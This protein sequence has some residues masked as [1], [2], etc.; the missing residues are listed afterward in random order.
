MI[1]AF[2]G[3][4]MLQDLYTDLI[5]DANEMDSY[6]LQQGFD[7]SSLRTDKD[8]WKLSQ[9]AKGSDDIKTILDNTPPDEVMAALA[10]SEDGE[11]LVAGINSYAQTWGRRSDTVI[12]I[13]DP[14]W[15]E[16]PTIVIANLKTYLQSD[17]GDPREH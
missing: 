15:V 8:L 7:N 4:S 11:Q 1:P 12:E 16:D 2:V 10:A 13:G 6:K 3:P 9:T 17:A 5:E 14:S